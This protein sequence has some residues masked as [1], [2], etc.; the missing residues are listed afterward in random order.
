MLMMPCAPVWAQQTLTVQDAVSAALLV[1]PT[2]AAARAG[3]A[4]AASGAREVSATLLPALMLDAQ[5]TRFEERM[6]VAPLHGFDPRNPP[7]FDPLLLQGN[8]TLGYTAF[9]GGARGARLARAEAL[10][11]AA[12]ETVALVREQVIADVMRG[13][14]EVLVARALSSAHAARVMALDRERVRA[15][16]LYAEGRAARLVALRAQAALSAARAELAGAATRADVAERAL[17]RAMGVTWVRVHGSALQGVR[18]TGDAPDREAALARAIESNAELRRLRAQVAVAE[19]GTA[20]AQSQWYPRMQLGGRYARYASGLGDAGGEWQTGLQ[21][22]YSIFTAGARPAARDRARAETALA[23][24][25]LSAAELRS[26]A[27]VDGAYAQYVTSLERATAWRAAV[28]QSAEVARIERL[29]LD[30]GAGV[31]S[32]YLNA[33]AELLRAR[34]AL[35]EAEY[36][37]F[38]ARVELARAM[39]VLT[40]QWIQDNVETR[41]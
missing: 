35:T 40:L 12:T 41:T 27:A 26:A 9:D 2:I 23:S 30:A 14:A 36:A 34:A 33:E 31:Q 37:G 11:S 10:V 7:Q 19:A 25:E 1:H 16:S 24:A 13:Y 4:R 5:V 39:G 20:E 15:E 22:S 21:L 32:D 17:A 18:T 28:D 29:S 38:V 8:V 6:V 3:A